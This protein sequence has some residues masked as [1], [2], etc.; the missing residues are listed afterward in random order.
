MKKLFFLS[1]LYLLVSCVENHEHG[2]EAIA[3]IISDV[4]FIDNF[5]FE[6]EGEIDEKY[7]IVMSLQLFTD[8]I[9][10]NYFYTKHKRNILLSGV[11]NN[12]DNSFSLN[13]YQENGEQT[14]TFSGT[15]NNDYS[16]E[17]FWTA[18]S[19]GPGRVESFSFQLEKTKTLVTWFSENLPFHP[20]QVEKLSSMEGSKQEVDISEPIG[21]P[22]NYTMY[23]PNGLQNGYTIDYDDEYQSRTPFFEYEYLGRNGDFYFIST[24]E[25]GGGTGV[26]SSIRILELEDNK[27]NEI[28]TLCAG[29]RCNGGISGEEYNNGIITFSQNVTSEDLYILASDSIEKPQLPL[30]YC[31]VCCVGSVQYEYDIEKET[32]SL[33]SFTSS[34]GNA[35]TELN[36]DSDLDHFYHLLSIHSVKNDDEMDQAEIDAFVLDLISTVTD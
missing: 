1:F 10:G 14:G 30:E 31:A 17:G 16:L 28:R 24:S 2:E 4:P 35:E 32:Y 25:S 8:R 23:D 26:F 27:L 20:Y 5:N 18:F 11:F 19:E 3:E 21:L 15:L 22:D 9:T 12:E 13:E 29:D 7:P 34:M 6:F 33:V 36:G